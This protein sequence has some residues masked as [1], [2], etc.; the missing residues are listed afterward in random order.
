MTDASQ[1]HLILKLYELRRDPEMRAAR[2]WFVAEFHPTSPADI[3][4]VMVGGFKE[5]AAYRMVTTYWE[6]AAALVN[7]GCIAE[8]LFLAANS[9]HLAV[10]SKLEPHIGELRELFKEPGYLKELEALVMNIPDVKP[11]LEKRRKLF[12]RWHEKLKAQ[13]GE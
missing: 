5:S 8:K 3:A 11:L 1:G 4:T 10:F 2:E 6:M 12:L 9:E 13:R 7:Q